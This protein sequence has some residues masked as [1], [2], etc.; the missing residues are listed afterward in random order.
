M[1]TIETKGAGME[2]NVC[3]AP[4]FVDLDCYTV[5]IS[6]KTSINSSP[7]TLQN[8]NSPKNTLTR[9]YTHTHTH[10]HT[11]TCL[12]TLTHTHTHTHTCTRTHTH[13]HTHT[14]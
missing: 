5:C 4:Y 13:T 6:L 12:H 2:Q 3:V 7:N 1:V 11:L 9:A 8:V 10:T 14:H